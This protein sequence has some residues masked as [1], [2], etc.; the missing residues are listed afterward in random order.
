MKEIIKAIILPA[1]VGIL[2]LYFTHTYNQAQLKADYV[3]TVH[4][5]LPE[6]QSDDVTQSQVALEILRPILTT[7]QVVAI[8]KVIAARQKIVV[9]RAVA[10]NDEA[11]L[12]RVSEVSKLNPQKGRELTQYTEA[13]ALQKE[14]YELVAAG[15]YDKAADKLRATGRIHP[16]F[17]DNAKV[18]KLLEKDLVRVTPDEKREAKLL[19]SLAVKELQIPAA[20][21]K[22][23]LDR[24]K[25]LGLRAE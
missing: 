21:R 15:A 19:D 22:K 25:T 2:G 11:M 18:A 6:I 16:D 8:E 10:E 20:E 12:A 13:A 24:S 7:E 9:G 1:V 14:G 3:K 4:E 17:R 23:I 5:Y